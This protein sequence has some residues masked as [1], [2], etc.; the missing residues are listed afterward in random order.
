[1]TSPKPRPKRGAISEAVRIIVYIVVLTTSLSY[2]NNAT[3][4]SYHSGKGTSSTG[5]TASNDSELSNTTLTFW[6]EQADNAKQ[7][8]DALEKQVHERTQER[9][10]A[11]SNARTTLES[12]DSMIANLKTQ[13][14]ALEKEKS[15]LKESIEKEHKHTEELL[16]Q[17]ESIENELK[18]AEELLKQK[19]SIENALKHAEKLLKQKE[20]IEKEHKHSEELVKQKDNDE[21]KN[22][23]RD[24]AKNQDNAKQNH[25][26][27]TSANVQQPNT[28]TG[29]EEVK[30]A[31]SKDPQP[32]SKAE[33]LESNTAKV[34]IAHNPDGSMASDISSMYH[35]PDQSKVVVELRSDA[36]CPRPYLVGRLSGPA[37][38]RLAWT[39]SSGNGNSGSV[40]TGSYNVPDNGEYFLEILVVHCNDFSYGVRS[41]LEDRDNLKSPTLKVTGEPNPLTFNFQPVCTEDPLKGRLTSKTASILVVQN[42][43]TYGEV[44]PGFWKKTAKVKATALQTRV[45]PE[46]CFHEFVEKK[47]LSQ[48]C[49]EQVQL[50]RFLDYEFEW[51]SSM[52]HPSAEVVQQSSL[53]TI[54]IAGWS[55]ARR[56]Y[57]AAGAM[58]FTRKHNYNITTEW[59]KARYPHDVAHVKQINFMKE[60]NCSS[61]IIGVTQWP[62]SYDGKH[63]TLLGDYYKDLKD[64]VQAVRT[65]IPGLSLFFRSVHTNALM[66]ST[67]MCPPKDWRTGTAMNGYNEV[68]KQV[69]QEMNIQFLDA[70]FLT[71]PVWDA[72]PDYTHLDERTSNAEILYLASSALLFREK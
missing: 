47:N 32:N 17:K 1:M 22:Q 30:T 42:G 64:M 29:T 8:S 66:G 48:V 70:T 63:P 54:C 25:S 38:V 51:S 50:D 21:T 23:N 24:N 19:E 35:L 4:I 40:M 28:E 31:T 60:K 49:H 46:L 10:L 16:K 41:A 18:H 37:L 9:D 2:W 34:E 15:H 44:V 57:G 52:K 67:V 62:A 12:K 59:V 56:L 65:A 53:T 13:L 69:C 27:D 20:S 39:W 55:H 36:R 58:G 14:Q 6:R 3:T 33:A 45:Q 43:N 26:K 72:S 61:L 7:N 11:Q 68:I 5:C 71:A